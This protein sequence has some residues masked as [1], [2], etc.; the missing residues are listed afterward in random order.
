MAKSVSLAGCEGKAGQ[1]SRHALWRRAGRGR[2]LDEAARGTVCLLGR[3]RQASGVEAPG[4]NT[5]G[6]PGTGRPRAAMRRLSPLVPQAS[7]PR[8]AEALMQSGV[9]DI[10]AQNPAKD[11][12]R[13]VSAVD[14]LPWRRASPAAVSRCLSAQSVRAVRVYSQGL[15]FGRRTRAILA[16][17]WW[18]CRTSVRR[19][20]SGSRQRLRR[21]DSTR[22]AGH[23]G[24]TLHG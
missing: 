15:Q 9:F 21:S 8:R 10:D 18:S 5:C 11:A 17:R 3:D 2:R 23:A 4:A 16:G 22:D 20:E 19:R 6:V 12:G 24:R 1:T 14:H 7:P 13:T